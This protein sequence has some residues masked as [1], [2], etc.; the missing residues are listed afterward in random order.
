MPFKRQRIN[1]QLKI[2]FFASIVAKKP[3]NSQFISKSDC[4]SEH[5]RLNTVEWSLDEIIE[6][7]I[8]FYKF[9]MT[10]SNQWTFKK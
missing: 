4:H 1:G 9:R 3:T 10:Y 5:F 8:I 6:I 2:T 7:K